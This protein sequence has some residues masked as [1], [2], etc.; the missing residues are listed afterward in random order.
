MNPIVPEADEVL[1]G[2]YIG[3]CTSCGVVNNRRAEFGPF[4]SICVL[5]GPHSIACIHHRI[6]SQTAL[7]VDR[8]QLLS[9]AARIAEWWDQRRICD[10]RLLIH[11]GAGIERS[12]LVV[13]TWLAEF[14]GLTLD[15]A[16]RWLKAR[17]PIVEDR[18][19]WLPRDWTPPWL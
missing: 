8:D 18:R 16:Y 17:R 12:P 6:L 5:E 10:E 4:R 11:C 15:E 13:A 1:P 9:A 14:C 19:V 2:L 7:G 3:T